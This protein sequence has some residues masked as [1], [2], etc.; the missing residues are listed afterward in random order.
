MTFA[1]FSS[2]LD[3]HW[4]TGSI[5]ERHRMGSFLTGEQRASLIPAAAQG[6]QG[7]LQIF[8]EQDTS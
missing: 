2:T 7:K 8:E 3:L 5:Q 1:L 6:D 4:I